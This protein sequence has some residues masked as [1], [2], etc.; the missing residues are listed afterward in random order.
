[1]SNKPTC[2]FVPGAWHLP[3]YFNPLIRYLSSHG[4]SSV[5]VSLP[6]VNS[7]PALTSIQ[8]NVSAVAAALTPLLD[9]GSDVV[10]VMHSYGGMVGTN[11]VG[12]V[13]AEL[14]GGD[15]AHGKR[16]QPGKLRR[17][18]YVAAYLP[19]EGQ[20]LSNAIDCAVEQPPSPPDYLSF[21][22]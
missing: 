6:G 1:M 12:K 19:L 22:V 16:K 8:P 7:S 3:A 5:A 2:V 18:I 9:D 11:V 17:L 4:Y 20:T 21:E 14:A 13:V 15:G 10:V